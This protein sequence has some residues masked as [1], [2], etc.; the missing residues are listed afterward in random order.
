MS[1]TETTNEGQVVVGAIG[2]VDAPPSVGVPTVRY[3]YYP[4]A[5]QLILWLPQSGYH[6]Y[7]DVTRTHGAEIVEKETVR[8]RLNGSVQI[9][10]NTLHWPPGNYLITITHEEGWRHEVAL[11]KLAEGVEPPAPEPPDPEPISNP[12]GYSEP[13][14][15]RDGAG[16]VIPDVEREIREKIHRDVAR[17][18]ARKLEYEGTYRAGTIIYTDGDHTIRFY[19]EMCG[20]SL[21]FSIDIPAADHWVAATGL[22]LSDREEIVNF[23]AAQVKRDQAP[24]WN[25]R[26]TPNTIDFY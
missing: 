8:N 9:L 1:D 2:T 16:N 13:I 17:K 12:P 19:H 21:H 23:V 6:G 18:F 14:V 24:T 4:G 15:Y 10:W 22:P 5:Q 11:T 25:Y 26:I 3:V 7:R 20:G